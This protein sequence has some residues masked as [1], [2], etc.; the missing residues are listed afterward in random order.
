[1]KCPVEILSLHE[2]LPAAVTAT[3]DIDLSAYILLARGGLN[4]LLHSST[5]ADEFYHEQLKLPKDTK[6]L[7]YGKVLN[8]HARHNL[9]FDHTAQEPDYA[10]GKGRVVPYS[11]VPLLSRVIEILPQVVGSKGTNL[12]AEGNYYYDLKSCGIGF[13]GDSERKKVVGVRVGASFPLHFQWFQ[14]SIPIPGSKRIALNIN[15][16]DVYIFSEKATGQDWKRKV[17]P[18]LRH[19]AGAAKYLT[20]T[21]KKR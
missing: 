2:A 16:G 14:N 20:V 1:M 18:T 15:H 19:A 12:A 7:M 9:C 13:H 5:G 21:A 3:S 4:A 10:A 11:N 8:K 6:A 17:I